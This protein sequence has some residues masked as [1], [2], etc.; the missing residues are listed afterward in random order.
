[1]ACVLVAFLLTYTN[2]AWAHNEKAA[3]STTI[4][5]VRH[6][7]KAEG[8][9]P[10]LTAQGKERAKRLKELLIN[11]GITAIYSTDYN[12]TKETAKPL[13]QV[14][15]LDIQLYQPFDEN[16]IEN[17]LANNKGGT[18]LISGHSN[19]TPGYANRFLKREAFNRPFSEDEYGHI[20][21]ITIPSEGEPSL[22][23][24]AY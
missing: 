8:K 13:A 2:V 18:I 24:L 23:K 20:L 17:I 5:L 14:L 4:I 7:E 10:G 19:T 15:E 11:A 3:A 1:M 16:G 22:L 9:D 12:R 6:A 21:I